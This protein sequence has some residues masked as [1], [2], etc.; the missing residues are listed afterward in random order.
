MKF[1]LLLDQT[2]KSIDSNTLFLTLS[3]TLIF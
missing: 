1:Y 2:L 3:S